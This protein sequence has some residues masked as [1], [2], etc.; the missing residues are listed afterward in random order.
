MD[1]HSPKEIHQQGNVS[2]LLFPRD[3]LSI[4]LELIQGVEGVTGIKLRKTPWAIGKCR[5]GAL[6]VCVTIDDGRVEDNFRLPQ[7]SHSH[8][9]LSALWALWLS[10]PVL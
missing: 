4:L 2:L 5:S 8:L 1:R 7:T 3:I 6:L 9:M 10:L